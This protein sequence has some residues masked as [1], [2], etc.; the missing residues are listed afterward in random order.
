MP[1]FKLS[2]NFMNEIVTS[3]FV[4][5]ADSFIVSFAIAPL[6]ASGRHRLYWAALFGICD[7]LAVL[8]GSAAGGIKWGPFVANNASPIFLFCGGVYC[9]I[10]AFWN[11]FR[12]DPRLA[13][14]LPV[15]LSFDNLAYGVG[16]RSGF[17]VV[18]SHA[19]ILGVGSV[20][21]SALGFVVG[22]T[23]RSKKCARNEMTAGLAMTAAGIL[24]A[25]F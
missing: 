16:L 2:S 21:M 20:A 4:F 5:G 24:L 19:V 25:S 10:A 22:G 14:V 17:S 12:A 23:L 13:A 7:A 3:V 18:A 1:G 11:R 15:L 9:L 6:V 8:I